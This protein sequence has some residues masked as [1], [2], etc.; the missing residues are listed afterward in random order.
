MNQRSTNSLFF[1]GLLL[2]SYLFNLWCSVLNPPPGGYFTVDEQFIADSGVMMLYGAT[3]RCL[4]WPAMP[5]VLVFYALGVLNWLVYWVT[6]AGEA[7]SLAGIFG[8]ADRATYGYLTDRIPLILAGR[9]VQITLACGLLLAVI[10]LVGRSGRIPERVRGPLLVVL[11]LNP[12]TLTRFGAIRPEALAYSLSVWLTAHLLLSDADKRGFTSRALLLMGALFS[13]RLIFLFL[14][15]FYLGALYW[16]DPHRSGRPTSRLL[17]WLGGILLVTLVCLPVAWTDSLVIVKAFLG[18]MAVKIAGVTPVGGLNTSY[19]TGVL[20]D[21]ASA[22][23]LVLTLVGAVQLFRLYPD[24]VVSVLFIGSTAL[25]ALSVLRSA[26]IFPTHTQPLRVAGLFLT[27]Y[28]IGAW[29]L[30]ERVGQRVP[31]LVTAGL[32][33]LFV[34]QGTQFQM[35]MHQLTNQQSVVNWYN[36]LPANTTVAFDPDFNLLVNRSRAALASEWRAMTDSTLT[37]QKLDRMNQ[38]LGGGATASSF[39]LMQTT[40][41]E[42]ERMQVIQQQILA[43]YTRDN[44]Y[45]TPYFYVDKPGIVSYFL[46]DVDAR[47]RFGQGQIRYWVSRELRPN[48]RLVR[49]FKALGSFPYYVYKSPVHIH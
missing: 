49:E 38:T 48:E 45:P 16:R 18:G 4:D 39:V 11:L 40:L 47:Q 14:M 27:A 29:Q 32:T 17:Y 36:T 9:F 26:T 43:A 15:P 2:F 8:L 44:Q 41:L 35:H 19:L 5:M 20:A 22:I 42:D 21:P 24:R 33:L 12:D 34:W 25:Y 6:H 23:M 31:S 1:Y 10:R 30:P 37:R 28:G 3:P 13:Q 7:H 46:T